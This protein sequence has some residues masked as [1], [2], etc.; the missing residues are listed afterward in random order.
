MKNKLTNF[1]Y[2]VSGTQRRDQKILNALETYSSKYDVNNRSFIG[3]YELHLFTGI[4]IRTIRKAL[5]SLELRGQVKAVPR[6][7]NGIKLN[8]AGYEV[9]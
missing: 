6:Y 8:T 2:I 9:L 4:N 5:R 1:V 3:A 7:L